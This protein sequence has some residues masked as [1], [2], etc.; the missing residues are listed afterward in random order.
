VAAVV[1]AV[2]PASVSVEE[3]AEVEEVV[4]AEVVEVV[5]APAQLST[6]VLRKAKRR[7]LSRRPRLWRG[8]RDDP[9]RYCLLP[10][11]HLLLHL[12]HR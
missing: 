12:L 2:E 10:L 8:S 4:V 6:Q 7:S 5:A 3:V 11:L 9:Q 1:V